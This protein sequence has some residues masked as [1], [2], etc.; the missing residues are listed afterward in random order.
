MNQMGL[1]CLGSSNLVRGGFCQ[2]GKRRGSG[3]GCV[4]C[5][6]A[7]ETVTGARLHRRALTRI[8]GFGERSKEEMLPRLS[9]KNFEVFKLE[10]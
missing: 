2:R 6:R 1:V 9:G 3:R 8:R 4:Q 10:A 7:G 5:S